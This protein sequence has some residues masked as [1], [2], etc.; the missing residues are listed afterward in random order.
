MACNFT[1][2]SSS[3]EL[4]EDLPEEGREVLIENY[5]EEILHG[6]VK[7]KPYEA[8]MYHWKQK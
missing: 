3:F 8:R 5:E 6:V 4:P 1:D 2:E 7:M